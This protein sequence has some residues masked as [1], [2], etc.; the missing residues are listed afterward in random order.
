MGFPK[1][2][3]I[4]LTVSKSHSRENISKKLEVISKVRKKLMNLRNFL[5]IMKK[6][7]QLKLTP[8]YVIARSIRFR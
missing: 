6:V 3:S 1:R 5:V 4:R 2:R 7:T 8:V